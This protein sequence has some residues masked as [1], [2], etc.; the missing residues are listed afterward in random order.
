MR[1]NR[2]VVADDHPV[3]LHGLV[4]LLRNDDRFK[5]AA[6]CNNGEESIEAIRTHVPELA[7]LDINMP[8]PNGLEVLKLINEARLPTRVIFLAAAPTDNQVV[9]A[10]KGGAYGLMHK[11]TAADGLIN[12]LQVVAAGQKWFPV[13]ILSGALERTREQRSQI[14]RI[15]NLL[16]PR[17]I[18]VMLRVAEG[19]TNRDVGNQLNISEGTVKIHLNNIY[20]KIG[21]SNR[22]ALA[23]FASAYRDRILADAPEV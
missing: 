7:L 23:N 13:E 16:T 17:E 5:V 4:T 20:H 18:E 9:A 2:I 6:I 15:E 14:G 12:C 1:A 19:L 11:E 22:T 8:A 21:V 3:V 10:H